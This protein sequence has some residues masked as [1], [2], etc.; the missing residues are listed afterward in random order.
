[1]QRLSFLFRQRSTCLTV[2]PCLFSAVTLGS[3]QSSAMKTLYLLFAVFCLVFHVQANPMPVPEDVPQGEPQNLDGGIGM[4][5]VDVVE[6]PGGQSNP[7]V[8][9]FSGGTCRNDRCVGKEVT[10]GMC[11]PGVV[12]CIRP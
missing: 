3:S 1:M 4:E 12:C 8:C 6:A 7:M 11:Y 2:S 9:S 5:D 10:S